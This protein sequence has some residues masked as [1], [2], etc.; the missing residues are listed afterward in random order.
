MATAAKPEMALSCGLMIDHPQ[1][2]W[3]RNISNAVG[4]CNSTM[5]DTLA[6]RNMRPPGPKHNGSIAE[7]LND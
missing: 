7:T 4:E 3:Q 6:V 1:H 5:P 2:E